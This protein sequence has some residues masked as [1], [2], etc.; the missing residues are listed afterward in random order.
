M[1]Y[2]LEFQLTKYQFMNVQRNEKK[3]KNSKRRFVGCK[4]KSNRDVQLI[5]PANIITTN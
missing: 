4:A 2:G 3:K 5:V 1:V